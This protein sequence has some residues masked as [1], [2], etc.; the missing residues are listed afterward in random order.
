MRRWCDD[1]GFATVLGA[2]AIAA[3]TAIAAAVL[4]VGGAVVA[5]HRAQSAADLAALAAARQHVM[6]ESDPCVAARAIADAQRVGARLEHCRVDGIDVVVAVAVP[7]HLGPFG[8]RDAR[9][10]ARAGPVQ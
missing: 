4:Y 5:R 6:A 3:V 9:A 8:I 1:R 2:F 7:V 10:S